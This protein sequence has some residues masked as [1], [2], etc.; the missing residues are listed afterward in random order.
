MRIAFVT[1]ECTPWAST[2]GLAEAVASLARELG[3]M[4][5][6]VSL[7]LPY[8]RQVAKQRDG[9]PVAV[10]SIT[11]PFPSYNRFAR[12]LDGGMS[13]GV[14]TYFVDCPEFFDR[15]AIYATAS[16]NYPDNAERF[17]LFCRASLEAMKLVGVPE[18]VHVH[19]WPTALLPVMLRTVY[20]FDP[21]L[22]NVPVVLTIHNAG[23]HGWFPPSTVPT[24]L[25]PADVYTPERLEQGGEVNL[26]K[27]GIVYADALTT[28]SPTY[29]R[30]IQTPEFGNGLDE[31]LRRRSS[32]L[33]GILNGADYDEWNPETDP[34]IAG[35]YSAADL[36]GKQECRRDLLH[37]FNSSAAGDRTAV[38][39]MVSRFTTQK[40]FDFL[41]EIADS[42]LERDVVLVVEGDGE[43]HYTRLL[44]QLADRF[45]TKMRVMSRYDNVIEHKIIAGA[46]MLLMPSRYEPCGLTQMYAL[47]YG[48][49]PVVRATGGLDDTIDEQ[50]NGAGNGFKFHGTAA[51]D[52]LAAIGRA[53][54]AF[55]DPAAW[56]AIMERG[57]AQRFPWE[58]AA[59]QYVSVY[60]KTIRNRS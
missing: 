20:Y 14:R 10:P 18:I 2:G 59:R 31:A 53:L 50:P 32:E 51:H 30:E 8:Y 3:R 25:L 48:T 58:T 23:Y 24:L 22:R 41:A 39:G 56:Q 11:I 57:M 36:R 19:D 16:G 37:A 27:G 15:E 60:E 17:G 7:Y 45:P 13:D 34:S 29:A 46:D 5:H 38:L 33:T 12:V 49:V 28:V 21:L 1:P 43:E 4:G 35:H 52:L 55:A 6:E 47:R 42:L 26:L 54:D 9:L 40:G 44:E